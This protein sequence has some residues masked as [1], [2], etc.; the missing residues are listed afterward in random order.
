MHARLASCSIYRGFKT[1]HMGEYQGASQNGDSSVWQP[2][3]GSG[4]AAWVFKESPCPDR[5]L[6]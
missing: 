5:A 1:G 2:G 6:F 4:R 3:F